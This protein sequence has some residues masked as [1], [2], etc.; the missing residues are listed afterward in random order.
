MQAPTLYRWFA[1]SGR[2]IHLDITL[3]DAKACSHPGQCDADV[4][5]LINLDRISQQLDAWDPGALAGEL[6]EYGAWDWPELENHEDNIQ[7]MVWIAC[8]DVVE[9][10]SDYA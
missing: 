10:P 4:A 8:C 9:N 3:D 5:E 1:G 6:H 2:P 7:R